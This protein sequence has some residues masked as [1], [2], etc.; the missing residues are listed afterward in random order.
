MGE[1]VLAAN[2]REAQVRDGV[3]GLPR[4]EGDE[5]HVARLA[6]EG[7]ALEPTSA[8]CGL[9]AL[10]KATF[11]RGQYL[12]AAGQ[13]LSRPRRRRRRRTISPSGRSPSSSPET[14]HTP[15]AR[16]MNPPSAL[17]QPRR[18][19][20]EPRPCPRAR[21]N[22]PGAERDGAG[23]NAGR[24]AR[25]KCAGWPTRPAPLNRWRPWRAQ[26]CGSVHRCRREPAGGLRRSCCLDFASCRAA[27]WRRRVRGR[28]TLARPVATPN[29]S[30]VAIGN[31]WG[32]CCTGPVL[33]PRPRRSFGTSSTRI[34]SR[35]EPRP[36]WSKCCA[37]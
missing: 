13:F 30:P 5:A 7:R 11:A 1:R 25:S 27:H 3:V 23:G 36:R 20:R 32:C 21:T 28:L 33:A 26:R 34:L 19:G 9:G 37:P 24:H 2:P 18:L 22:S 31:R 14:S 17:V 6:E 16:G 35:R 4:R 8:L 29:G 10:A 12:Q 15:H